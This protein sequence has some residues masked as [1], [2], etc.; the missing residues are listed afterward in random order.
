MNPAFPDPR[1]PVAP[2][3]WGRYC[4]SLYGA[5]VLTSSH[6]TLRLT[7]ERGSRCASLQPSMFTTPQRA[8]EAE[9]LVRLDEWMPRWQALPAYRTWLERERETPAAA[10]ARRDFFRL[11]FITKQEIREHSPRNFLRAGQVLETLLED[12]LVELEHTSGTSGERVPVLLGRGWWAA[13]EERALR[14][15]AFVARVLDAHPQPRRV[16]LTTPACSGTV[17]P[18]KWLPCAH[19]TQGAARYAN[20]SRIPFLLSEKELGDMAAETTEWAPQFLDVDPVHGT[21][22]ALYCERQGIRFP[23][24]EF[25]ICSYEFVS[26][27]HQ[28]ILERVFG[29]P[30]INLYGATETGHL[31]MEDERGEMRPSTET[32]FLEVVD[33]DAGGI[34][35]LVVTTLSNEFTPLVRYRIGDLVE[36]REQTPRPTYVVHGRERDSLRD[37]AGRRVTTWQVDQCFKE[38]EGLVHYQ[39]RQDE[40]GA[41]DLRLVPE[42]DGLAAGELDALTSRLEAQLQ[43]P[44]PIA[45]EAV[46]VLL[47]TPS[48][49]FRLTCRT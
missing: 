5:V 4:A 49:K 36:R 28:R 23:T 21:W 31:L 45:T 14:L 8:W 17:C 30:V 19:R 15:N 11:P 26:V 2:A 20:Q 18:S 34:G 27:V 39:L 47:P 35:A 1:Y 40:N 37:R 22:F 32:A 16:V 12:E 7:A 3:H 33:A 10:G 41:C 24:L 6:E 29:V 46:E 42:G 48:G 25:V 38:V 44:D 13:Q 9:Q 43:L